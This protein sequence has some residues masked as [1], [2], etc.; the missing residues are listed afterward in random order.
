MNKLYLVIAIALLT[1]S[2]SA[3]SFKKGSLLISLSEGT[4]YST[5]STTGPADNG[6]STTRT[7]PS[8]GNDVLHT[9]NIT[10]T[11]DP[12]TIEYGLTNHWGLGIN[13]GGDIYHADPSKYYGF[14]TAT[15]DIKVITSEL[16]LDANYHFFVTRH[17]DLAAFVSLGF[18]SVSF[19][20]NEGDHSYQY[21]S[22]GL[23]FRTGTKAR[24]YITK[25]FGVMGMLSTF[26][27]QNGTDGVKGNT[28]GNNYTTTLKGTA[29]E[30]GFVYR[31]LR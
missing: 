18:S 2:A 4:T 14:Q 28:V 15:N 21:K 7:N 17:F 6:T 1:H 25:R 9:G 13:M 27:T 31:V 30:F 8:G 29:I 16:T 5:F 26:I 11:R 10:G 3:Q 23:L 19:N 12:I 20:G 24:Y 22:G